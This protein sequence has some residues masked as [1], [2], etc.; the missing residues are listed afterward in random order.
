MKY[1]LLIAGFIF[2]LNTGLI[3]SQVNETQRRFTKP[4]DEETSEKEFIKN[5]FSDFV[6]EI[7]KLGF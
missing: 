1:L 5:T 4:L 3:Y 6:P 7:Y 2:S